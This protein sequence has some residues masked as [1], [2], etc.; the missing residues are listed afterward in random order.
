MLKCY[1]LG[2]KSHCTQNRH[3]G[4]LLNAI[5]KTKIKMR[6][7]EE[8]DTIRAVSWEDGAVA[9]LDQRLLPARESYLRFETAQ[10]VA[11]AIRTMVVRG[12]PAIGIAAAYGVVLGAREAY[13]RY[14]GDWRG[15]IAPLLVALADA[16]PTAINLK[17]A[18][19]RMTKRFERIEGDPEG[20]LLQAAQAI[21]REDIAANQQMGKLG[22]GL[23]A[24]RVSVITHCNAGSLATGGY[25]TALGVIR[26]AYAAGKIEMVYVCETRPWL[27]GARLTA[28]ELLRDGLPVTLIADSAAAY[29]MSRDQV[30]WVITGA[31][32][33]AANGDVAN[34]IGTL[35]HAIT[36]RHYG[37]G[38]MVAAPTSTIDM[39]TPSGADIPI[40]QRS[41]RELLEYAGSAIAPDTANAYN[42]VFDVTPAGLIARLV[43]ERGSVERPDEGKLRGLLGSG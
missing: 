18:I 23:I 36:A 6:K 13:R 10:A 3:S 8:H 34:K 26:S 14:G 12:A 39:A 37:I 22:A 35:T 42:P 16:R 25:G 5:F 1:K 19:E 32:R 20:V 30:A 41:S 27:Q 11:D 28:W 9:M 24:R 21:H 33:I 15:A 40:E 43:T 38:F 17:W 29:L 31:D 2:S 4:S 7:R